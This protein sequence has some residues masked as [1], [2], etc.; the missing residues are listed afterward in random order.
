MVGATMIESEAVG[1]VTAKSL[2]ELLGA[3][4]TVHP[5][6]GEAELVETGCDLRPAFPDNLPRLR[7]EGRTLHVNGLFRHG[8]LLSPALARRATA[9]V[10]SGAHFP[11]IMN[12]DTRERQRA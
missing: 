11:E 8:F 10:L 3:A 12:A 4:Y 2:L 1:G 7:R 9:V 5:A 6:F